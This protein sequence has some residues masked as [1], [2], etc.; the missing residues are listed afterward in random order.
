MFDR[1]AFAFLDNLIQKNKFPVI[2]EELQLQDPQI[3]HFYIGLSIYTFPEKKSKERYILVFSEISRTKR[4]Q[5]EIVHMDRMASLGALSSGIAHEIRNPLAG[6]KAMVQSLEEQ[7]EDDTQK[8]EY[9]Q[10]ILRQVNRLTTLLKAFF[11][12]ARPNLPDPA[13][14]YIRKI[15][16]EV[17][18][19]IDRKLNEK[20][21]VFQQKYAPDLADVFVDANQ[22]QQVFLNLFLNAADAMPDGGI[23]EIKAMNTVYSN[24]IV[25]RRKPA[26]G[27]LSDS[28]VQIIVKDTGIGISQKVCKKIFDPFYSSKST[29]TGL[30]L[31]IVYQ[32][33]KEHG[34]KIDVV[35]KEGKGTEFLIILPA[36]QKE[37][38]STDTN[39]GRK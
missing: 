23:L 11:T 33:I 29:G 16:D 18:P 10:R 15:I 19:L 31:S 14:V 13:P 1:E 36:F 37:K 21:I 2:R 39:D 35:S 5:A 28:F 27:L 3:P 20:K 34:G 7:L 12:Y 17:I 6:I 32:I 38:Q 8:T 22:I 25:D 9:I 30:G 24:P 26:S 4:I